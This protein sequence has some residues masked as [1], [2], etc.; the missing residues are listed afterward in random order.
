[1]TEYLNAA[2]LGVIQG[3]AEFLPISSSGHL[4]IA[5]EILFAPSF[6]EKERKRKKFKAFSNFPPSER[7]LALVVGKWIPAEAVRGELHGLALKVVGDAF[8]VDSVKLFD[9]YDGEGLPEGKKSL[10]LCMQ[11][12]S[13]EKT[14]TDKEVQDVFEKIQ[15]QLE[16]HTDYS[17]RK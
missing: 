14:L 15:A 1:M 5:G 11:F 10:G 9:V 13:A 3:I 16:E 4:V 17:I 12:R 7:D 8:D 6:F 2:V